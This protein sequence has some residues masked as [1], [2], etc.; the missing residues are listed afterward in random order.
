MI[1]DNMTCEEKIISITFF[2]IICLIIIFNIFFI[3]TDDRV[4]E[5]KYFVDS[6]GRD[7]VLIHKYDN[8]YSLYPISGK[9]EN[10]STN[11]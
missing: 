6:N 10:V 9:I 7:Y 4:E 5:A 8:I 3:F 1:G 11:E 2:V